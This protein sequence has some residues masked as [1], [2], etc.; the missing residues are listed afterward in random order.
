MGRAAGLRS[1]ADLAWLGA[2]FRAAGALALVA[3]TRRREREDFIDFFMVELY[4]VLNDCG[5]LGSAY[6]ETAPAEADRESIIR[7]YLSGSVRQCRPGRCLQYRRR[8][9]L[10]RVRGHRA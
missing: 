10:G 6:A 7:D 4:L 3:L 1:V 8:M 5:K 9:V 2:A